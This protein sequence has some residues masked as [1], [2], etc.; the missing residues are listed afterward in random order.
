MKMVFDAPVL[1]LRLP[2][3][4][5]NRPFIGLPFTTLSGR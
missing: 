2:L 5:G 1:V 3:I 4:P